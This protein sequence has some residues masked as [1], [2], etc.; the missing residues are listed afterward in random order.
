MHI[1]D[2]HVSYKEK[3]KEN[4]KIFYLPLLIFLL[5]IVITIIY[6]FFPF[7]DKYF[8]IVTPLLIASSLIALS[9][10]SLIK[11]KIIVKN[12]NN[13]ISKNGPIY[14]A[15]ASLIIGVYHLFL[16]F[17]SIIKYYK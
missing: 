10:V 8:V 12:N 7:Y 9:V 11:R 14:I 17:L 1:K 2:Q 15:L 16:F 13:I 6:L 3:I 4:I 5:A